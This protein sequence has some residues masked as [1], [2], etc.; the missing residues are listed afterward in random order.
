M[1]A[2][3]V[4]TFWGTPYLRAPRRGG[5]W[6]VRPQVAIDALTVALACLAAHPRTP[7]TP[8]VALKTLTPERVQYLTSVQLE[9]HTPGALAASARRTHPDL[10]AAVT[11]R[12]TEL[13]PELGPP[14]T[15]RATGLSPV[16][17]YPASASTPTSKSRS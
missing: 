13:F 9:Q 7:L 5:S 10:R 16:A 11:A 6:W 2:P 1:S 14:D 8:T 12:V 17:R 4:E 3:R 15:D